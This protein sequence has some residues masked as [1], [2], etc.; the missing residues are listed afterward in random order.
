MRILVVEAVRPQETAR[1]GSRSSGMFRSAWDVFDSFQGARAQECASD[2]YTQCKVSVF[3]ETRGP[4]TGLGSWNRR[5]RAG[6]VDE[7]LQ[8]RQNYI[9]KSE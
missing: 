9:Y 1:R 4:G 3:M 5:E 2:L 7:A 8:Y 6:S